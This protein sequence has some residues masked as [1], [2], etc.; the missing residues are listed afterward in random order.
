MLDLGDLLGN[1]LKLG[2]Q[3]AGE[4]QNQRMQKQGEYRVKLSDY[5]NL[6]RC[7]DVSLSAKRDAKRELREHGLPADDEYRRD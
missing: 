3:V 7:I 5:Q 4:V 6:S 2:D 1:I